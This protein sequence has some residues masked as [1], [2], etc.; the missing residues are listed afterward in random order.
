MASEQFFAQHNKR[1]A[2]SALLY[3]CLFIDEAR[4]GRHKGGCVCCCSPA[5]AAT[6]IATA[7]AVR[8]AAAA[9]E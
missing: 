2:L 6:A 9:A 1:A 4:R 5:R 7:R 8:A 3:S